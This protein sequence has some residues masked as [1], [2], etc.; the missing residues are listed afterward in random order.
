[1][2]AES[3]IARQVVGYIESLKPEIAAKY[4]HPWSVSLKHGVRQKA[5]EIKNFEIV[6]IPVS[7]NYDVKRETRIT[8][9]NISAIPV[10]FL[11]NL[12]HF[13]TDNSRNMEIDLLSD[14]VEFLLRKLDV[15]RP[16]NP[17]GVRGL[18]VTDVDGE[19]NYAM[20]TLEKEN[21][22]AAVLLPVFTYKFD[23]RE[24]G[25]TL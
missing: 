20:E 21:V 11:R 15:F 7:R 19:V 12:T 25:A 1:M 14:V 6:V 2:A 4:P 23:Q 3:H 13:E 10:V 5:K 8:L 17:P 9:T 22:F 18:E 16:V 24:M